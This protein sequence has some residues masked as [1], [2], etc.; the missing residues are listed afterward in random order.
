MFNLNTVLTYPILTI[1]S[2]GKRSF[3]NLGRF[4]K[5]SGDTISRL[6]I[7]T[8]IVKTTFHS[9]FENRN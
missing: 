4:L 8:P 5:K 2:T 1:V 3:E 9:K 7:V 6:F